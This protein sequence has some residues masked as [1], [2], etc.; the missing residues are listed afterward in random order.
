M[1]QRE[2]LIDMGWKNRE[3]MVKDRWLKSFRRKE[4]PVGEL[5]EMIRSTK[6]GELAQKI[7][8]PS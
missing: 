6:N 7:K 2:G 3:E 5:V 8:M 4:V 1:D